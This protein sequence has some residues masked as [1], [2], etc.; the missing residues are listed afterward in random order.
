MKQK[1]GLEKDYDKLITRGTAEV[2]KR[3]PNAEEVISSVWGNKELFL[4][5]KLSEGN[6]VRYAYIEDEL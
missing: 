3:H 1:T 2:T 5:V 6:W 4:D